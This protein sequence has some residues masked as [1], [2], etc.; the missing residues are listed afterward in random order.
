MQNILY[1][2]FDL[3]VEYLTF[4]PLSK[5]EKVLTDQNVNLESAETK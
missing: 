1:I 2:Y 4:A 5:S 3:K